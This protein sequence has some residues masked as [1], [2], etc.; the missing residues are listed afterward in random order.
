MCTNTQKFK[1]C[2]T[3][4]CNNCYNKSFASH[5]RSK[6]WNKD[7]NKISPINVAKYSRKQ[8]YFDCNECNH[9]IL[10]T[11]SSITTGDT[12]CP[13]CTGNNWKHCG[14]LE[15]LFCYNKSFASH[16]KYKYW[17][18]ELNKMW[19]LFVQ[20]KSHKKYNFECNKCGHT[21]D[22]RLETIVKGGW[23]RYCNGTL[24]KH[25]QELECKFCYNKSFASNKKS[26][27]W[28]YELN[29]VWPLFV[30]KATHNLFF[31][32]CDDC[33]H[34]FKQ[35]LNGIHTNLMWCPYCSTS[36]KH[37]NKDCAY[38]FKRSFA[39]VVAP[40]HLSTK[41]ENYEQL[42]KLAK[43]SDT[44]ALFECNK[45][46]TTFPKLLSSVSSKI[47]SGCP[48][49]KNKTEAKLKKWLENKFP[50]FLFTHQFK[51][52]NSYK[53][54]DFASKEE[55][56][57]IELDG[58]QHFFQICNWLPAKVTQ[59]RD[60]K[61]MEIALQHGYVVIRLYQPDVWCD[62]YD[63]EKK[64]NLILNECFKKHECVIKY[65]ECSNPEVNEV[66][67]NYTKMFS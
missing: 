7:K 6:Y 28:N 53:S 14:E 32:D 17:N 8:F 67:L 29:K 26:K 20:K 41:N 39:S 46:N 11:I 33:G 2:G 5:Y 4:E 55:K 49:C 56:I 24:W 42:L 1:H 63:W 59:E 66:Y 27:F 15:C 3:S 57:I 60:I 51:F 44:K 58:E 43:H 62:K 64:L 23:C 35:S 50:D 47:K 22:Q 12:W 21:F 9:I 18:Y 25:C 30:S 31:F 40:I 38:C 16:P 45:C 61:K 65:V 37:C 48:T 54:Y 19:P 36:W 13:Y 52:N 10:K 34:I